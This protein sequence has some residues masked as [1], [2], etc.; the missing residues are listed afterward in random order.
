MTYVQLAVTAALL[1]VMVVTLHLDRKR[2]RRMQEQTERLRFLNEEI[3]RIIAR[4]DP[5]ECG[6]CARCQRRAAR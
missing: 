5:C 6:E 4:L 3:D 1:V 2:A